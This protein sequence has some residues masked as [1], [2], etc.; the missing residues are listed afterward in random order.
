VESPIAPRVEI[1]RQAIFYAELVSP[2]QRRFVSPR[3]SHMQNPPNSGQP[4][5]T[6]PFGPGVASQPAPGEKP[7][8]NTYGLMGLIFSIVGL[9]CTCAL[10]SPIGLLLSLIGLRNPRRGLA[11]AGTVV[12]ALGTLLLLFEAGIGGWVAFQYSAQHPYDVTRDALYDASWDID[13][14]VRDRQRLLTS[15]EGTELIK[16]I[17]DGWGTALRYLLLPGAPTGY[18]ESYNAKSYYNIRS[19]GPD[20]TFA[21]PDDPYRHNY[22]VENLPRSLLPPLR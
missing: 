3:T 4:F 21:T 15:D 5:P 20:R 1:A 6:A 2:A 19:A 12:G 16:H 18:V 11:I 17:E 22:S 8:G 10:L 13:D 14:A 7:A 9:V